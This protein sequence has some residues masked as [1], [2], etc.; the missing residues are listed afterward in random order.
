MA[1]RLC[2]QGSCLV[3]AALKKYS[4]HLKVLI[5]LCRNILKQQCDMNQ[6]YQVFTPYKNFL[7]LF[8]KKNR[9]Q[10]IYIYLYNGFPNPSLYQRTILTRSV[11]DDGVIL[12]GKLVNIPETDCIRVTGTGKETEKR[13]RSKAR[14]EM[15]CCFMI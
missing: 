11:G 1:V 3:S 6:L 2:K 13:V 5:L 15:L 10:Y 12:H 9:K 8:Y 14:K 7:L 4:Q